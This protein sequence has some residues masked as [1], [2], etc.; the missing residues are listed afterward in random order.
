MGSLARRW[1]DEQKV[2]IIIPLHEK[3][4]EKDMNNFRGICLLPIM[5][6]ILARILAIR[7]Q[8]WA[9]VAGA[10]DENQAGFRQGRWTVGAT[11]IFVRIHE[12]VKVVC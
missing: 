8:R 10:L 5:S 9:E 1:N 2:G 11:Q 6:R 7:L 3:G 4:D 12:D